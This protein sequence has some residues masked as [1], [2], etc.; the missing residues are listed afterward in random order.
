MLAFAL[1][2]CLSVFAFAAN[3]CWLYSI[4]EDLRNVADAAALAAAHELVHDDFLRRDVA[5]FPALMA[6]AE[7]AAQTYG[8]A[9]P[10]RGRPVALLPNPLNML[11]GDVAFGVLTT[12]RSGD[13]VTVPTRLTTDEH[14][15]LA[16]TVAV[17]ARLHKA[18][19]T[20]VPLIF[21]ALV[22]RPS[23]DVQ[24]FSAATLDR[25]VRGFRPLYEPVPL[26]P[27]AL[28]SDPA[29][30]DP[31]S[32]QSQVETGTGPDAMTF[33]RTAGAF[34]AAAD[35]IHEFNAVY[36]ID[37]KQ[38]S[39]ANVALLQ[40]GTAGE[41]AQLAGGMTPADFATL[42]GQLLLPEVGG[43]SVP[44]QMFGPSIDLIALVAALEG[45]QASAAVRVWPLYAPS[46]TNGATITDFIAARVVS[47]T[48]P[49]SDQPLRFALQATV[50]A[51]PDALTDTDLRGGAATMNGNRYVCKVR[52]ID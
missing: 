40:L 13:F 27:V 45:L 44:A 36:P 43:L 15:R 33:D 47:V 2:V 4:R 22:V 29:G 20:A 9:N 3:K 50:I 19:G 8:A 6:R 25:G 39:D 18:R 17:T 42:G 46:P 51:R 11:G 52:R 32:W 14:Q 10:V 5:R 34:S 1:V 37:P 30:V 24:S 41:A 7:V 23:A 12:P 49:T 28:L 38:L 16:N 48:P 26:A 35:G 31:R 21:G